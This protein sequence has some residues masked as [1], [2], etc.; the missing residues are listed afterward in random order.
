M[1]P[2]IRRGKLVVITGPMFAGKTSRL[3]QLLKRESYAGHKVI[4]FKPDIDDRY[5]L[6]KVVSHDGLG[7]DAVR[8]KTD[9]DGVE[10]IR[11]K[12][13]SYDVIGIDEAQFWSDDSGLEKLVNELANS[14]KLVYLATLNRDYKGVPFSI[15]QKVL[16]IA[17]E[18]HSLT[19]VCA[20]CGEEAAFTYRKISNS[21]ERILV[22]GKDIYEPRC[23]ECFNKG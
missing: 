16:A 1:P 3:I 13:A 7:L 11:D 9:K 14:R 10:V 12:A 23:R 20:V 8:V 18:I 6:D 21:N 15:A 5:S 19:A 22:G 2:E 4:L 17:D